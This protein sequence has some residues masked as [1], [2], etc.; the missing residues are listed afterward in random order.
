[1]FTCQRSLWTTPRQRSSLA[2]LLL[3]EAYFL[4]YFPSLIIL[5]KG[6][7][8]FSQFQKCHPC[9]F[10]H[11]LSCFYSNFIQTL[12]RFFLET[13]FIQILYRFSPD[14]LKF[15]VKIHKP[16]RVFPVSIFSS[17]WD[18]SC[19]YSSFTWIMLKVSKSQK[20]N[21]KFS[22]TPNQRFFLHFYALS[23]KK[24]LKQK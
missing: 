15:A 10:I 17:L 14:F 3:F 13:H 23:S 20:Q 22:N 1:M 11:M 24:C 9:P 21:T 12:S 8:I 2:L 5:A 16:L 4:W 18:L 6:G 19:Y 7:N